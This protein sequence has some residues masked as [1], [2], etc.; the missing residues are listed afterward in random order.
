MENVERLFSGSEEESFEAL[1]VEYDLVTVR[2]VTVEDGSFSAASNA[3]T[4]GVPGGV[5]SQS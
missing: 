3:G 4:R 5:R 2:L 1:I